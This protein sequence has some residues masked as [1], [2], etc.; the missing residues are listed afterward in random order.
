[1][2][3]LA[4]IAPVLL[5][6]V[7]AGL[8]TQA[9]YLADT[10]RYINEIMNHREHRL[11]PGQDPYW[12]F[13]HAA[14]RPLVNTVYSIFYNADDQQAMARVMFTITSVFTLAAVI[15]LWLLLERHSNTWAAGICTAAFVCTNSVLD[16]SRSGAPYIPALACLLLAL[17]LIARVRAGSGP[18][19]IASACA[20]LSLCASVALWF[21]FVLGVPAAL[22]YM[23][24][25]RRM[26]QTIVVVVCCSFALAVFYA[27]MAQ[28]REI[29]NLAGFRDW[30]RASQS[31]WAQT[32][33][34][35]RAVSGIPRSFLDLGDDTV[36][37]KRYVFHDPYTRVSMRQ[38][39]LAPGT[40]KLL[41][42]YLYGVVVVVVLWTSGQRWIVAL[43]A[44][45]A[46]PV[47]L[48]AVLLFEPG[49]TE[50]YLPA[51]PFFF[52][53]AACAL[54]AR[55]ERY[56]AARWMMAAF[57]LVVWCAGNL[58][59]KASWRTE[60]A[61][62]AFRERKDA[63]DSQAQPDSMVAVVNFW[64]PLYRLPALRLLDSQA[65]PRH[66]W[67]Y[68]VI[69]TASSRVLEWRREF[70]QNALARW[71]AGHQ[72]WLSDRLLADR[73]HPEWKWIEGDTGRVQWT[74]VRDFFR[75][76]DLTDRRGGADGFAL[77]A[78]DPRNL[79]RLR[80]VAA[81]AK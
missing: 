60:A 63:L 48:F 13:G 29:H 24:Y 16:Y 79:D 39:L 1:M 6:C 65:Q 47:L 70:A 5:L 18:G 12:E 81:G 73:P 64:D 77:L 15:F 17:W 40:L 25:G 58:Y 75:S 61:Y 19:W 55:G 38:I 45:A 23:L 20:G 49:G 4:R 74:E 72:V 31:S 14:W 27:A 78:Q 67:V 66:L 8:V 10:Q 56:G 11:P 57:L 26:R 71:G 37:L 9:A 50:R 51:Y 7:I 68:D 22:V 36:L 59:A 21:P 52:L 32:D 28:A 30:M 33:R 80:A 42:F 62:H 3:R 44:A 41:L 54:T 34:A 43:L 35:K 69:E 46:V 2:S 76:F 53:A